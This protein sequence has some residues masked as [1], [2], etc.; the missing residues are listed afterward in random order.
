MNV[1]EK[2]CDRQWYQLE[3]RANVLRKTCDANFV[4]LIAS[5]FLSNIII[6]LI[7]LMSYQNNIST[8][9]ESFLL[10]FSIYSTPFITFCIT[11]INVYRYG[12][13]IDIME[14]LSRF[15]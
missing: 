5:F 14:Y 3:K 13:I 10:L 12:K 15:Y 11:A 1:Y 8:P 9:V 4:I 6:M 7:I 2:L